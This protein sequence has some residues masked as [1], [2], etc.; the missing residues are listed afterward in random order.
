MPGP[1]NRYLKFLT[2]Y[3]AWKSSKDYADGIIDDV[4]FSAFNQNDVPTKFVGWEDEPSLS[5]TGRLWPPEAN[6]RHQREVDVPVDVIKGYMISKTNEN[7]DLS[8][9]SGGDNSHGLNIALNGLIDELF[10][11]VVVK[12]GSKAAIKQI[13]DIYGIDDPTFYGV[14]DLMNHSKTFS[15][16]MS[17]FGIDSK[18][19]ENQ[20]R[21]NIRGVDFFEKL[22]MVSPEEAER[23]KEQIK[24]EHERRQENEREYDQKQREYE[25]KEREYLE[26]ER[27]QKADNLKKN[28]RYRGPGGRETGHEKRG[29][30]DPVTSRP[31]Q[32][33]SS[34]E[35]RLNDKLKLV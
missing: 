17:Q 7:N 10:E 30:F 21:D 15:N 24:D 1:K 20:Y 8:Q 4:L 3:N 19:W 9:W 28:K 5:R 26:H 23:A 11:G 12:I 31:T 18:I 13:I 2:A 16:Y 27:R 14:H 32:A 6:Y 35:S 34:F 25:R 29:A 33:L 22:N